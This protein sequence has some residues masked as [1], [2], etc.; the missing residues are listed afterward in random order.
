MTKTKPAKAPVTTRAVIQRINRGL[1]DHQMLRAM[2]GKRSAQL[3]D[4]CIVDFDSNG[5]VQK[6]VD[7]EGLGRQLGVIKEWEKVG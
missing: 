7:L 1:P 2:R 5:I 6:H 4:Y 3:G